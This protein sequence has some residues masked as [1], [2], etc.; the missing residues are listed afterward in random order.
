MSKQCAKIRGILSD[1]R[2]IGNVLAGTF[3]VLGLDFN[4][5]FLLVFI[6]VFLIVFIFILVFILVFIV[7]F[8]F[9]FI[10]AAKI[11][12]LVDGLDVQQRQDL[13]EIVILRQSQRPRPRG[14]M[15]RHHAEILDGEGVSPIGGGLAL[16]EPL[17]VLRGVVDV[18]MPDDALVID[19]AAKHQRG[20]LLVDLLAAL[21]HELLVDGLQPK[22]HVREDPQQ[23]RALRRGLAI[24]LHLKEHDL[25]RLELETRAKTHAFELLLAL[26]EIE[27]REREDEPRLLGHRGLDRLHQPLLD[28][29]HV[30]VV[31]AQQERLQLLR[32]LQRD[33]REHQR[34]VHARQRFVRRG[35]G[36]ADVPQVAD[37]RLVG[38]SARRD[39]HQRDFHRAG[40]GGGRGELE[41]LVEE[42]DVLD[43]AAAVLEV[44]NGLVEAVLREEEQRGVEVELVDDVAVEL[45]IDSHRERLVVERRAL[46]REELDLVLGSEQSELV[47]VA[48]GV[49]EEGRGREIVVGHDGEAALQRDALNA[50]QIDEV[51]HVEVVTH[52][53]EAVG[54]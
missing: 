54:E 43:G 48:G 36:L 41:V 40:G 3:F 11:F 24:L 25:D 17:Q 50:A 21:E 6:V 31:R 38:L 53:H 8:I 39:G 12:G 14:D 16:R 30:A 34:R 4:L 49:E 47:D 29:R 32:R 5:V 15:R 20:L 44:L 42:E 35:H 46:L 10:L 18:E 7:V 13:R 51:V 2:G 1:N 19:E 9:V 37:Q 45:V 27:Q 28:Q 22:Q 26:E 23:L 52:Q 33:Q